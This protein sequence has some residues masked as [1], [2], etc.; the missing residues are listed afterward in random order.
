MPV[1][2]N[3]EKGK[4][5]VGSLCVFTTKEKAEAAYK[6]YLAKKYTESTGLQ[7]EGFVE[8]KMEDEEMDVR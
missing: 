8:I 4:W 5:C 7:E 2:Y 6:A 3:K 1:I